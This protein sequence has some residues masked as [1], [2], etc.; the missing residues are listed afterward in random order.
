MLIIAYIYLTLFGWLF[1]GLAAWLCTWSITDKD[2][3]RME[4]VTTMPCLVSLTLAG[5][6]VW[7]YIVRG[8]VTAYLNPP[9]RGGM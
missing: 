9:K 1:S 7:F 8:V 6:I 4:G 3:R 5:P 2:H